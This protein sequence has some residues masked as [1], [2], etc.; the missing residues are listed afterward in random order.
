MNESGK[1]ISSTTDCCVP[2]S[3]KAVQRLIVQPVMYISCET[4]PIL[5]GL[6]LKK[7]KTVHGGDRNKSTATC[8]KAQAPAYRPGSADKVSL[9]NSTIQEDETIHESMHERLAALTE[10]IMQR[11]QGQG[12]RTQQA[13]RKSS[14]KHTSTSDRSPQAVHIPQQ[15]VPTQSAD[16]CASQPT[17]SQTQSVTFGAAQPEPV[18][19]LHAAELESEAVNFKHSESGASMRHPGDLF[20]ER[21]FVN[22]QHRDRL[23]SLSCV[24]HQMIDSEH[25]VSDTDMAS[26]EDGHP[27]VAVAPVP[28]SLAALV[29]SQERDP[30]L[31]EEGMHAKKKHRFKAPGRDAA[32]GKNERT[33]RQKGQERGVKGTEVRPSRK[34]V[35]SRSGT[36]DKGEGRKSRQL[37][38]DRGHA[39]VGKIG[40]T[41]RDFGKRSGDR[42]RVKSVPQSKG[43][44]RKGQSKSQKHAPSGRESRSEGSKA[45]SLAGHERMFVTLNEQEAEKV[46][47]REKRVN[48]MALQKEKAAKKNR[49][50]QRTRQK[51]AAK[52]HGEGA[53]HIKQ[54]E[55]GA[56][57]GGESSVGAVSVQAKNSSGSG[58]P[59]PGEGLTKVVGGSGQGQGSAEHPSWVAKQKERE[60]L[61]A[62][63]RGKKVVF[64]DDGAAQPKPGGG[65][66]SQKPAS[67]WTA[68][69]G[70]NGGLK[71]NSGR[72]S[73]GTGGRGSLGT[74]GRGSLGTGGRG[75][76]GTGGRAGRGTGRGAGRGT[77]RGAGRGAGRDQG[78]MR[79]NSGISDCT[80][81]DVCIG[82]NV[83]A[84]GAVRSVGASKGLQKKLSGV[85]RNDRES[86]HGVHPSWAAKSQARKEEKE[87]MKA[88]LSG[89]M[90]V[91]QKM[92]FDD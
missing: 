33:L 48:Y 81:K 83:A 27:G 54:K 59:A 88:A 67:S 31:L 21:V 40:G 74:A 82:M 63:P 65:V 45:R 4:E 87:K 52:V 46:S 50:G 18:S 14:Q 37:S 13:G 7:Q 53:N 71:R 55:P 49:P 35:V 90:V 64:G 38:V 89:K 5:A 11:A 32:K 19:Q 76:L 66:P 15:P 12:L 78:S 16:I 92:T 1:V 57:P 10:R 79:T 91:A 24:D 17:A 42:E 77:G 58:K 2:R 73:L 80:G 56:M 43:E 6:E 23:D 39:G 30:D 69:R 29:A 36:D 34:G 25:D 28:D 41:G 75:Y 8:S 44:T 22:R 26:S 47:C 62:A 3:C 70:G 20:G 68:D 61:A 60:M 85:G 86:G 72:G 84:T 9:I 51:I